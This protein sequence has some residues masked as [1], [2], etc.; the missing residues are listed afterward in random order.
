MDRW[1]SVAPRQHGLGTPDS[2]PLSMSSSN[3]EP[4]GNPRTHPPTVSGALQALRFHG[5]DIVR[6]RAGSCHLE[7]QAKLHAPEA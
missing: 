2:M 5:I 7:E 4:D 1:P 3:Y 6:G